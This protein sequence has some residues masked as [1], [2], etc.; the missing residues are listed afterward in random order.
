VEVALKRAILAIAVVA[1]S[2]PGARIGAQSRGSTSLA[3][4]VSPEAH[5]S[6]PR[7]AL[8]FVVAADGASGITSQTEAIAAW[9][10]ALPG[11]R[12]R[13]IARVVSLSGPDGALPASAVTWNGASERAT[14]G[15]QSATCS[16]GSFAGGAEQDLVAGWRLSGTLTCAVTVSLANPQAL[17][18]GA[19]TGA[20]DLSLRAE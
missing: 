5:L 10:R 7:V 15:G 4:H 6:T 8:R 9:V 13:L 3:L 17:P 14:A 19:Y 18:P 12:I 2:W 16:G 20:L 1:I 11:Q